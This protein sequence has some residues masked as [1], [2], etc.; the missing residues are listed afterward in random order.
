MYFLCSL[1]N[2]FLLIVFLDEHVGQKRRLL[3]IYPF[4][5]AAWGDSGSN[6]HIVINHQKWKTFLFERCNYQRS[7]MN[8]ALKKKDTAPIN[9]F[10]GCAN[11]KIWLIPQSLW[12]F[13]FFN[14]NKIWLSIRHW[15]RRNGIKCWNH[16][17][18]VVM[19][20]ITGHFGKGNPERFSYLQESIK[21]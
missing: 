3:N 2:L 10:C 17:G 12:T 6:S 20:K 13:F 5:G 4:L 9:T 7:H 8:Y 11:E 15:K 21:P 16:T 19:W 14:W 18:Y 1:W